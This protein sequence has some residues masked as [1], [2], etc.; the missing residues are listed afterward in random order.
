MEKSHQE[1]QQD[2]LSRVIDPSR[3][4]LSR[5]VAE[6][7][8]SLQFQETDIHRMNELAEKN[9]RGEVTVAEQEELEQYSRIGN[10][11]NMLQSKARRSLSNG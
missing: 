8:L 4:G 11:L 10:L 9:R 3:G 2:L 1:Y 5:E 6:T 7:F